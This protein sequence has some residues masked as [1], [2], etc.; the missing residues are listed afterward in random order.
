MGNYF[1]K[2]LWDVGI[3]FYGLNILV[4]F[5]YYVESVVVLENILLIDGD[6]ILSRAT[7][8]CTFF[9]SFVFNKCLLFEG[10]MWVGTL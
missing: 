6:I 8:F 3:S 1:C 10:K 9:C 4:V 5:V 2:I 7:C